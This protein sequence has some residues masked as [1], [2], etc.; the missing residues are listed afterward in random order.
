MAIENV[1]GYILL[2]EKKMPIRKTTTLKKNVSITFKKG[3]V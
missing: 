2:S 3:T 1:Q